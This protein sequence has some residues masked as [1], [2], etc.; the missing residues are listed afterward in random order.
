[1]HAL[2]FTPSLTA[3]VD[4]RGGVTAGGFPTTSAQVTSFSGR[5]EGSHGGT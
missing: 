4:G 2:A 5:E 3:G 1:M